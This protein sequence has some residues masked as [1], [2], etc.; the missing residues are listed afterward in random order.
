MRQQK[1]VCK[2]HFLPASWVALGVFT[3]SRA[4]TFLGKTKNG[5]LR[6]LPSSCG[7]LQQANDSWMQFPKSLNLRRSSRQPDRDMIKIQKCQSHHV[8]GKS[9]RQFAA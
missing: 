6:D 9:C 1:G 5:S 2:P 4:A 8:R 3:P 7:F